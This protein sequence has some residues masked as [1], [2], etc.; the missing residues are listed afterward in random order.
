MSEVR[1]VGGYLLVE[2]AAGAGP[3]P[4]VVLCPGRT[5]DVAS[6]GWL[7][8]PLAARGFRVCGITYPPEARYVV[9]DPEQVAATATWLA[10]QGLVRDG[11]LGVVG[12]SRGGAVA[13][14]SAAHDARF[15]A[16]AALSPLTDNVRYMR[17]LRDYAPLRYA[18]LLAGRQATPDED[19]TYYRAISALEHVDALLRLP[20]LLVHG[21][22]DLVNPTD[23]SV[24]LHAALQAADHPD[25]RLERIPRAGH[26]YEQQHR[27]YATAQVADLVAAWLAE[28]AGL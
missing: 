20:V 22:A 6:L 14:L 18:E 15:R 8:E 16:V 28:R 24:W 2:P 19:P 27:G 26:F 23:H 7:A 25:A 12:H 10:D 9:H 3:C 1:Q 4:T 11:W 21:E 17:A 5:G 13:L